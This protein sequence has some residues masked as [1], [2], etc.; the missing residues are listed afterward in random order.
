MKPR[1]LRPLLD[2][3]F[4]P[5]C[6]GCGRID[7]QRDSFCAECEVSIEPMPEPHC[8]RCAEPGVENL[9]RRCETRPPG[10]QR[11]F[12]AFSHAGAL[13]QAIHALKYRDQPDLASGLGKIAC[14]VSSP[15]LAKA[16]L[17]VCAIPLHRRRFRERKYDQ[18]Q[19]LARSVARHSQRRFWPR[20]LRRVHDTSRQVGLSQTERELNLA[21]AFVANPRVSGHSFLVIDDV[22]TTGATARAAADALLRAGALEVQVLTLARAHST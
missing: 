6:L 20:A 18:A 13:A 9:C 15:F 14:A 12:A 16:P 3:L 17:D 4:P 8:G 10:F 1:R 19:L 21:G 2:W 11:A 7:P 5:Q 22:L